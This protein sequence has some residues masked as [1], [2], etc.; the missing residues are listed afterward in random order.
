MKA[1][2]LVLPIQRGAV[3]LPIPVSI[4]MHLSAPSG[5]FPVGSELLPPSISSPHRSHPRHFPSIWTKIAPAPPDPDVFQM[6]S[7]SYNS[8][9]R[10]NRAEGGGWETVRGL[11]E[12]EEE[13]PPPHQSQWGI[14]PTAATALH[15]AE[16]SLWSP[17]LLLG[18]EV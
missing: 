15:G 5:C 9:Q 2:L 14:N 12:E 8:G 6:F 4:L 3:P 7:Q 13:P 11:R 18:M 17:S 1:A 16:S 10:P